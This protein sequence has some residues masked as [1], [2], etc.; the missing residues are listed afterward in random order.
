MK[1]KDTPNSISSPSELTPR[2][3]A[4]N[5]NHDASPHSD[6]WLAMPAGA[7]HIASCSTSKLPATRLRCQSKRPI[8]SVPISL[9]HELRP[10]RPPPLLRPAPP[11]LSPNLH[12]LRRTT[13][14]RSPDSR[15]RAPGWPAE[16][17]DHN[18]ARD[19]ARADTAAGM[20]GSE[21]H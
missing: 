9:H 18:L 7:I 10:P 11:H 8:S 14:R 20:H 3:P 16:R 17:E 15:S 5:H 6:Q 4:C 1:V 12:K 19:E 2:R 21:G 13:R